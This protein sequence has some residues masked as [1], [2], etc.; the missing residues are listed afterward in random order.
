MFSG[1]R[2]SKTI[3]N[4]SYRNYRV[5]IRPTRRGTISLGKLGTPDRHHI[6]TNRNLFRPARAHSLSGRHEIRHIR[7]SISTIGPNVFRLQYR[8]KR[9]NAVNN[10]QSILSLQS[11]TSIAGRQGS[12]TT[13]RQLTAHR[14]RTTGTLPHCRT[15]G[16]NSFLNTRRLIIYTEHR[17]VNQRTMGTTRVTLINGNG[18]RMIS[19]TTGTIVL[20]IPIRTNLPSHNILFFKGRGAPQRGRTSAHAAKRI[21]SDGAGFP[22]PSSTR[23]VAAFSTFPSFNGGHQVL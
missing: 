11:H 8:L 16:T 15:R 21:T 10:R 5:L 12:A 22:D 13:S 6:S 7:Q 14:T 20:R 9:R 2:I 4:R 3:S 23:A 18:A 17:T 1:T 19:V